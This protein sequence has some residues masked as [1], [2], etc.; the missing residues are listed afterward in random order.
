[1]IFSNNGR[2]ISKE[3]HKKIFDRGFTGKTDE[4]RGKGLAHVKKLVT[5]S[6]KGQIGCS[7]DDNS[8]TKFIINFPK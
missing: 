6:L 8:K 4:I 1:M 5:E 3:N 7:F 2:Q